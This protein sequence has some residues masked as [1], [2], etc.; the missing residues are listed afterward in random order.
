M[1][2]TRA[3]SSV[4]F[5]IAMLLVGSA[6]VR[7]GG[8]AAPAFAFDANKPPA[9]T[10]TPQA[11]QNDCQSQTPDDLRRV[12]SALQDREMA[13]DARDREVED[14]K[15]AL[16]I[17]DA[18]VSA[19]LKSLRD[20]EKRLKATLALADGAAEGDLSQLTDMYVQ[21]KPK[22]AAALF[23]Q[24]EP[25]FAAGFLSRMPPEAAAGILAGMKPQLAYAVSVVLAGRNSGVPTQ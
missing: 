18:A 25:R 23:E 19:K 6:G 1:S 22:D 14:R 5:V 7:F 12:L 17:A 8:V 13:L 20:T 9:E 15:K 21:M 2:G 24:M 3:R 4:L 11:G 16:T 10:N